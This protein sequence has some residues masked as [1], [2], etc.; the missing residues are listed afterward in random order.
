MAVQ[1]DQWW[2]DK[3]SNMAKYLESLNKRIN[4]ND[5]RDRIEQLEGYDLPQTFLA[6]SQVKSY[7]EDFDNKYQEICQ[8]YDIPPNTLTE[9][10]KNK[11]RRYLEL[12]TQSY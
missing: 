2:L 4:S 10:E 6:F 11:L 5:L 1:T 9:E 12:F 7:V 8:G 3:K